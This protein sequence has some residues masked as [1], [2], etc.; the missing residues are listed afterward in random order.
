[1][2]DDDVHDATEFVLRGSTILGRPI[3]LTHARTGAEAGRV[4]ELDNNF[5]VVLM[6]AIKEI[7]ERPGLTV[8]RIILRT[9]QP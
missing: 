7:R 8:T 3:S 2:V 1:V 6:D 5:A 9:G 4:M